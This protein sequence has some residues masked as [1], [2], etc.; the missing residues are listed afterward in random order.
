VPWPLILKHASFFIEGGMSMLARLKDKL[1]GFVPALIGCPIR[2][3]DWNSESFVCEIS[4]CEPQAE[5]DVVIY[6]EAF[7]YGYAFVSSL[8]FEFTRNN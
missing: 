3:I 2:V 4:P 6:S 5:F 1:R 7:N 8:D